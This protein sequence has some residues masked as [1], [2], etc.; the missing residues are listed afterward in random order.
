MKG[1]CNRSLPQKGSLSSKWGRWD[2]TARQEGRRKEIQKWRVGIEGP[3]GFLLL[4]GLLSSFLCI[5]TV[6]FILYCV[7]L[8]LILKIPNCS[9]MSLLLLLYQSVCPFIGLKNQQLQFS[10]CLIGLGISS[11]CRTSEQGLL[12]IK[13]KIN[14]R[15]DLISLPHLP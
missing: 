8:S 3:E 11:H 2:R 10:S 13:A 9:L 6:Q 5:C 15:A 7:N 1:L 14:P 12:S 4:R